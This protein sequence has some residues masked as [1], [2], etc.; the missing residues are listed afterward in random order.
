M[1]NN[2]FDIT[3]FTVDNGWCPGCGN[4]SIL[5]VIKNTLS[6]LSIDPHNV[7]ISSGIGQAAK[8]PQ[9]IN[10]NYFNGL[11]GRALPI[12]TAIKASN[13]KLLVFGEGGDGDMYGEGGNHFMH[14]VR[15]NIDI[16]HLVHDNMVYGLTKGQASPTS[17]R[18]FVTPLQYNGV[19]NEPAN[20]L[21]VA[22]S[23]GATFVARV[24]SNDRE[25]FEVILTEA[26]KHKGYAIIDVF[27]PCTSFNK[28]NNHLWFKNNTYYVDDSYD[29]SSFDSAVEKV[30]EKEKFPLGILYQ[31]TGVETFNE[32]LL[33]YKTNKEPLYTRKVDLVKLQAFV[34]KF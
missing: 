25:Q 4:F 17:Q 1:T 31:K 10:T 11:H 33:A 8:M 27:H 23:Y 18:G 21:A 15:R 12:A 16:V 2:P 3:Q 34:D 5:N 14:T 6:N 13:P 20:P 30:Y 22:L 28:V 29:K 9:Y 24:Y 19:T 7:V 32:T 26:I